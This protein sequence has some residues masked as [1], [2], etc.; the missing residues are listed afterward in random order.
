MLKVISF[1]LWGNDPKYCVGAIKN[2]RM[3][4]AV[5]PGWVCRF[6]AGEGVPDD[7]LGELA[8][9]DHVEIASIPY[10]MEGWM[11][12]FARFQAADD[13]DVMIS[14]DCDSRL[15]T[16]EADAVN[17]WLDSDKTF[18][19]MRDHP[20]HGAKILGG[21]WGCRKNALPYYTDFGTTMSS[22]NMEDRWQ[23]D[24]E[25]LEQKIYPY[26]VDDAMIHASFFRMEPHAKDFPTQ[27]RG[28]EFIGQVFDEN[29]VT[30]SE[31]TDALMAATRPRRR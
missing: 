2:A 10:V 28:S 3:S 12:M 27:R 7:V 8:S 15:T 30:V 1:S 6:Y 11:G 29:D 4:P 17:E 22:W 24:Q 20:W 25:F 18:H 13:A 5:Y 26:V 21:M 14:R 31:H 9:F 19:I 23:T 16:R